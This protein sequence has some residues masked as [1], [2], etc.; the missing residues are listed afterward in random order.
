[1]TATG[2]CNGLIHVHRP[3]TGATPATRAPTAEEGEGGEGDDGGE[4]EEGGEGRE[5]GVL[6]FRELVIQQEADIVLKG[7]RGSVEVLTLLA[8]FTGT[9][10]TCFL[11]WYKSADTDVSSVSQCLAWSPS[12]KGLLI[13]AGTDASLRFPPPPRA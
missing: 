13:S 6:G 9:H 4:Q 11:Y 8:S 12:E 5:G 2:D 10:S 7:H 1:M 3:L